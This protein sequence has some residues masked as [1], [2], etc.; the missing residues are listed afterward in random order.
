LRSCG[1]V[2][3]ALKS[4]HAYKHGELIMSIRR[5]IAMFAFMALIILSFG[6]SGAAAADARHGQQYS[7]RWCSQCHGVRLGQASP[8]ARAP[9]FSDLAAAPATTR[10]SLTVS[11][12]TT[13][14]WTMPK[15]KPKSADLN[16]VVSYI[17][18]LRTRY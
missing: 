5:N 13:P 9:S 15:I 6:F 4:D 16:D 2:C 12:Q 14:H 11:L 7:E 3:T 1:T 8:D 17:L 18:S 10:H